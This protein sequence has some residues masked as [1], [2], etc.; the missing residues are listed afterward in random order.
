MI[1]V[2]D[3]ALGYVYA[4]ESGLRDEV[5]NLVGAAS[6]VTE[7]VE[8]VA[9][10]VPTARVPR[11]LSPSEAAQTMSEATSEALTLN[12]QIDT[13]KARERLAWQPQY[14]NF[15]DDVETYL[16]AWQAWQN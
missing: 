3:L 9:T 15:A 14:P 12:Q 5:F 4:A 8:A 11:Y 1:H 6:T 10:A 16:A 2:D 7:M 13:R